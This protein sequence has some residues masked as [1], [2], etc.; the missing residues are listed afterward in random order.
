MNELDNIL[1]NIALLK[2]I[3]SEFWNE[4]PQI[5]KSIIKKD[6]NTGEII[7]YE[8]DLCTFIDVIIDGEVVIERIDES[9]NLMTITEFYKNDI[10]GGNLIFSRNSHYPMMVSAKTK[11][12]LISISKELV[13]Q[14]CTINS[15]FLKIFLEYISDNATLLGDKIKHYVNRSIRESLIAFLKNEYAMQNSPVIKL[16]TSKK[17]IAHRIGVQRTSL[18][19]ELQKMKKE[20]LINFD[21]ETIT[22]INVDIIV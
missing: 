22:I 15:D 13:F 10:L 3:P 1:K 18:S 17:D 8:G 14:L 12:S 9:G 4:N 6:Y 5:K 16:N 2:T 7:H 21:K 11:A 19:R 20:G